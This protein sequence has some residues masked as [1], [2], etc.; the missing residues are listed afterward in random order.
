MHATGVQKFTTNFLDSQV[1]CFRITEYCH[2]YWTNTRCVCS[3]WNL[4]FHDEYKCSKGS[5]RWEPPCSHPT[6]C[7]I[8][9]WVWMVFVENSYTLCVIRPIRRQN[10]KICGVYWKWLM[11]FVWC[12]RTAFKCVSI[13][14]ADSFSQWVDFYMFMFNSISRPV[15]ML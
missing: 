13:V 9:L 4:F 2:A 10:F 12:K 1:I 3:H 6:L 15:Q 11:H 5:L 14:W 7:S 8:R